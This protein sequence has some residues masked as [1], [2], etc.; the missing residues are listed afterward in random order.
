VNALEALVSRLKRHLAKEL[1]RVSPTARL[2]QQSGPRTSPCP[3]LCPAAAEIHE[4]IRRLPKEARESVSFVHLEGG[5]IEELAQYLGARGLE[6][7]RARL[8]RGYASLGARLAL[9]FPES[10][11]LLTDAQ[12]A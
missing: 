11:S 1:A 2:A 5:T 6:K 8:Q 3:S 9:P 7:A 4:A 12:D 10:F